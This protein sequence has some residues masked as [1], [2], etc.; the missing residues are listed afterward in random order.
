MKKK[1]TEKEIERILE[2]NKKL[3]EDNDLL[4][5]LVNNITKSLTNIEEGI[6]QYKDC[7]YALK[8][9][10]LQQA[11]L[12]ADKGIVGN[13][14]LKI[15]DMPLCSRSKNILNALGCVTLGDIASKEKSFFLELHGMG[16]VKVKEMENVLES[17]GLSFGMS[18]KDIIEETL[19][20]FEA[21]VK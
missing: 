20:G 19:K 4:H 7:V 8:Y 5:Q 15:V 10:R 11:Y 13:L 14:M 2:E 17:Y 18:V 6:S 21:S 16:P 3:K 9:F 1:L 12:E